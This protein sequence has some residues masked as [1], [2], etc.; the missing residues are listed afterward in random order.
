V[1]NSRRSADAERRLA[2]PAQIFRLADVPCGC[3]TGG[4]S[5]RRIDYAIV[6]KGA[7]DNPPHPG[8]RPFFS[9]FCVPSE[10][11]D[12]VRFACIVSFAI[13]GPLWAA[14]V[15]LVFMPTGPVRSHSRVVVVVGALLVY[16]ISAGGLSFWN[17][18][19]FNVRTQ[20]GR[21][22]CVNRLK[23][24][25]HALQEYH[26]VHGR[27]PPAYIADSQG[28]PVHS[29]RVLILPYLGL[30]SVYKAYNFGEP[31]N[32]PGNRKLAGEIDGA[33]RCP[34]NN[35]KA[36]LM[37]NYVVVV[38]DHT[39]FPGSRSV[40]RHDI[41]RD[42]DVIMVVE[43]ADSDIPWMEPRDLQFDSMSFQIDD[44]AKPSIS[45]HHASVVQVALLDSEVRAIR[46]DTGSVPLV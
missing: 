28:R 30:E 14:I 46:K 4:R 8:P 16:V 42:R 44:P 21:S 37:T 12:E 22:L 31:W 13:V 27:F 26:A 7:A 34:S 2:K 41:P 38:G 19:L 43:I 11:S 10:F 36:A 29:W 24:I 45:S 17:V 5:R 15:F 20:P 9:D 3:G 18:A 40:S 23:M 1:A 33:F 35:S 32:S 25:G 6:E 39:A